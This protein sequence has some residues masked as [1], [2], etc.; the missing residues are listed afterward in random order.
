MIVVRGYARLHPDDMAAARAIA[1]W[2]VTETRRENGCIDYAFAE[3]LLE[4]GL[5]RVS[6]LYRD[7]AALALHLG[8]PLMARFN[9]ELGKLRVLGVKV[10]AYTAAGERVLMGG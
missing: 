8:S 3:D 7:E 5:I 9:A 4:P 1:S 2:M 6:E 10:V